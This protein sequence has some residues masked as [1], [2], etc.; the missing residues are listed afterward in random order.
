M[1][2]RILIHISE[3][4]ALSDIPDLSEKIVDAC[5]MELSDEAA[6][7]FVTL[8]GTDVLFDGQPSLFTTAEACFLAELLSDHVLSGTAFVV[9]E[10]EGGTTDRYS[11][12]RSSVVKL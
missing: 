8:N 5:E 3:H 11:V 2:N 6:A 9:E 12:T 4:A 7:Q 1:S 10:H